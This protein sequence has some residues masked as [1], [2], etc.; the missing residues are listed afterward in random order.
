G[1]M[2]LLYWVGIFGAKYFGKTKPVA[3]GQAGVPAVAMAG[4]GAGTTSSNAISKPS[5]GD[6]VGVP[7]DRR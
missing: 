1:P 4:A 7:T 5:A 6:Y 2:F 3:E